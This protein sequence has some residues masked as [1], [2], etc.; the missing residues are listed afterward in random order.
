MPLLHD[1]NKELAGVPHGVLEG[2]AAGGELR[3]HVSQLAHRWR[4][5]RT[6]ARG[7]HQRGRRGLGRIARHAVGWRQAWGPVRGRVASL[8]VRAGCL[9]LMVVVVVL[10]MVVGRAA[11]CDGGGSG[12]A[13]G[14]GVAVLRLAVAVVRLRVR[15]A[16]MTAL[17]AQLAGRA[18]ACRSPPAPRALLGLAHPSSA[19]APAYASAGRLRLLVPWGRPASS[20]STGV[21][22]AA[23]T[24]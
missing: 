21:G 19:T 12:V 11:C 5:G 24:T 7:C 13:V 18:V 15:V 14:E 17:V 4:S 2:L 20:P 1:V 8:A 6:V 16:G 22:A 3:R 9:V 10:V 23:S